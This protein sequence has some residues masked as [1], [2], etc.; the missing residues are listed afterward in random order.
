MNWYLGFIVAVSLSVASL[1][2][3]DVDPREVQKSIDKAIA[4]LYSKQDE[5]GTWDPPAATDTNPTPALGG[6][7]GGTTALG[8]TGL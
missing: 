8:S 6:Q 5:R 1:T 3:A 4:F 2:R 7:W